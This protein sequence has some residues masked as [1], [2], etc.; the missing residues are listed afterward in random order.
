M[1]KLLYEENSVLDAKDKLNKY[2]A[3]IIE[4]IEKINLELEAIDKVLNTPKSNQEI[5][6]YIEEFKNELSYLNEKKDDFD[7]VITLANQ[8]YH[9]HIEAVRKMVG[10]DY[11]A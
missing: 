6:K 1:V 11:E 5:P 4:S 2:N 10:N 8:E 3:N 7:S 9:D